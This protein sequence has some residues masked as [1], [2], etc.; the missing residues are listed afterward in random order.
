[1]AVAQTSATE[2]TQLPVQSLFPKTFL[3]EDLVCNCGLQTRRRAKLWNDKSLYWWAS[4]T[5]G[6]HLMWTLESSQEGM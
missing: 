5:P 1:M 6:H 3:E 4:G 2:N